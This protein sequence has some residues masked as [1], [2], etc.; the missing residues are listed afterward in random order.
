MT[1]QWDVPLLCGFMCTIEFVIGGVVPS[2]DNESLL[3]GLH[4]CDTVADGDLKAP[5]DDKETLEMS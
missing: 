1:I 4:Y 5:V 3:N 2:A